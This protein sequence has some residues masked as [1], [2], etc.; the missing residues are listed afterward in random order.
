LN[1]D[2]S[3]YQFYIESSKELLKKKQE[4]VIT[5]LASTRGRLTKLGQEQDK[6]I[7]ALSLLTDGTGSAKKAKDN[8]NKIEAEINKLDTEIVDLE[9]QKANPNEQA[10]SLEK[11]LNLCKNA[12]NIVKSADAI[13]K[14]YICRSIFL[15]LEVDEEKVTN[16]RLKEPFE[17]LI[18]M[19]PFPSGGDGGN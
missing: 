19:R 12:A 5:Q 9:T 11:F 2:K 8:L 16:Y 13:E 18:K 17:S 1:F 6:M 4:M 10:I 15:N 7:H 3:H 14:D